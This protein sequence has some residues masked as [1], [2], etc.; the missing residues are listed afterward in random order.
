MKIKNSKAGI[1]V[2]GA[3]LFVLCLLALRFGS[4]YIGWGDF[5]T[6]LFTRK[7]SAAVIV[8][9]IRIPRLMGGLVS[10]AGLAVSGLLLQSITDN[11]MA[12]PNLVGVSSGAGFAVILTLS[13]AAVPTA[14]LPFSAFAGAF[15]A[16]LV[17]VG[18]SS[19][20]GM[21]KG[22]VVL[23]GLAFGSV[24][25]AGISLLSLLDS[26]VLADYNAFS[27]GSLSGIELSDIAL[28]AV[29]VV[30]SLVFTRVLAH[31][32]E[33]LS[34]GDTAAGALGVDVKRLRAICMLLASASA[35]AAV[36]FAGLLGFVGLM[37]PHISRAF[38]GADTR[39]LVTPTAML[40]A[41]L[42]VASD[43]LG[44]LLFAPSELPV[45]IIMSLLGAPFF[46]GLLICGGRK[47]V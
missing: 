30:V 5:F 12:S 4:T 40:G 25:S 39:R 31:R 6:A 2:I 42:V 9:G 10:G 20:L 44:R 8:Y 1:A 34:L 17:I 24:L 43:L 19:R 33:L 28:P 47:N 37:A 16:T 46:L 36:S 45:G 23:V 27:I 26:D 35:A 11:K 14:L 18:I 32:I 15:L 3:V 41:L 29:F 21:G 38:F 13:V 22:T 7:G